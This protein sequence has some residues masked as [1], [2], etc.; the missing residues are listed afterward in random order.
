MEPVESKEISFSLQCP[1]FLCIT[2]P[3]TKMLFDE[4]VLPIAE[5]RQY[6]DEYIE[7]MRLP[8]KEQ[9]TAERATVLLCKLNAIW[10][11]FRR[12]HFFSDNEELEELSTNTMRFFLIPFY[13]GRLHT[14]YQGANRPDHLESAIA[15]LRSFSDQMTLFGVLEEEKAYPTAPADRRKRAID[16]FHE[17]KALEDRLQAVNK[18]SKRDDL[19]RGFIGDVVDEETERDLIWTVLKLSCLEARALIRTITEELPFAKMFAQGVKPEEPSGPPP[20]MWVQRIER[21]EQRK[22]VFAPLEDVMPRPLPPDD[23]TWASPGKPKD[24]LDASDDEEAE[25]ARQEAAD[26]D[27]W[28][29]DHPPFS[30]MD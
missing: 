22:K 1:L 12:G 19:Q 4:G 28:K 20:K 9:A 8:V 21:E 26:W 29:Q 18:N 13:L 2:V 27:N 10:D 17:R 7:I 11:H 5:F 25:R 16:D 24:Q 23:E 30:S 14:V 6:E 15:I 3:L